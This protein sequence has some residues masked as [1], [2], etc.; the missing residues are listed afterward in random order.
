MTDSLE[1]FRGTHQGCCLSSTLF[2]VHI[3]PLT[4]AIWKNKELTGITIATDEHIIGLFADN[5]ITY[6]Q[7]PN[8]T[9]PNLLKLWKNSD[10]CQGTNWTLNIKHLFIRQTYELKW[11]AIFIKY[12]GVL[13]TQ[14]INKI[15][16]INQNGKMN[17]SKR[18]Q[19]NFR[20][21]TVYGMRLSK[22]INWLETLN[23]SFCLLKLPGLDLEKL[24]LLLNVPK[25]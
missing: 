16:E 22:I 7:D 11:E 23:L 18:C 6:R 25:K 21:N 1:L 3:E 13:I 14:D 15:Y 19:L 12:L 17:R 8:S 9:L 4:Q 2:T 20:R 5:L 24:I 10:R